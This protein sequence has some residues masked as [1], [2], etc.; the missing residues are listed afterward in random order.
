MPPAEGGYE[1]ID[2]RFQTPL[3]ATRTCGVE[4]QK[5]KLGLDDGLLLVPG[6]PDKSLMLRRMEVSG[7]DLP[8]NQR[9]PQ[10]GTNV[11]DPLGVALIRDWISA[12][13]P[14]AT[15]E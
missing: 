10:I 5:D 4:P 7:P 2:F 3:A 12:M 13:P 8:E 6:D 11:V 9:M 1:Q 14:C 15:P